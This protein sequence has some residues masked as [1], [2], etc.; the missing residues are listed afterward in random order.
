MQRLIRK[1]QHILNLLN[2]LTD[3]L[4]IFLSYSLAMYLRLE[5]LGGDTQR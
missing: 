1:N 2:M 3:G 5:V 4:L